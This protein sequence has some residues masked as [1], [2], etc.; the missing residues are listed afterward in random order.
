MITDKREVGRSA[1]PWG[2]TIK[3]ARIEGGGKVGPKA[4]IG[5]ELSE[6]GCVNLL[7]GG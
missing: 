5:L 3:D 6:I 4:D 7:I 1:L 2:P